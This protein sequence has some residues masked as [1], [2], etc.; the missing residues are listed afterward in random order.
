MMFTLLRPKFVARDPVLNFFNRISRTNVAFLTKI[1]IEG[2]IKP[3]FSNIYW[4][5]E[6]EDSTRY[7]ISGIGL[8]RLLPIFTTVFKNTC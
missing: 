6:D 3:A 4:D 2:S 8:G 7:H 5:P 1:E